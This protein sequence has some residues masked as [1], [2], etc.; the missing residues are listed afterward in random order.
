MLAAGHGAIV[1]E[2][3]DAGESWTRSLGP[4][5]HSLEGDRRLVQ[6]SVAPW[7]MG[8]SMVSEGASQLTNMIDID[9]TTEFSLAAG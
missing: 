4:H 7:A 3:F 2:F 6:A 8:F 1:A 5:R 9:L